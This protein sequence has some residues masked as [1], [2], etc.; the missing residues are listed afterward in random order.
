MTKLGNTDELRKLAFQ[1]EG[2]GPLKNRETLNAAAATKP[3]KDKPFVSHARTHGQT[4]SDARTDERTEERV[5][6]L[7]N[8]GSF[9]SNWA[10]EL[11]KELQNVADI[12]F[13]PG[14]STRQNTR[15]KQRPD[16]ERHTQDENPTHT[17]ACWEEREQ[18]NC[19]WEQLE[20]AG[21][22]HHRKNTIKIRKPPIIKSWFGESSEEDS[23]SDLSDTWTEVDK[24]KRNQERRRRQKRMRKEKE[25]RL[26][27][28]AAGMAGVGPIR[29]DDVLELVAQ[30]LDFEKAKVTT[31][32][33]FLKDRLGYIDEELDT[34]SLV[35]TKFA[36]K[37]DNVLNIAM[38]NQEHI[39]ELHVRRAECQDDSITVRNFIPPNYYDR[40]MALNRI[41]AEKRA[42][43]PDLKTQLRFGKTDVE[44]FIK[45]RGEPMG[46]KVTKLED[47]TD[48]S[49]LPPFQS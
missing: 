46:Y 17:P 2:S 6:E 10:L 35:E 40:Y 19:S 33:N 41:C 49:Q 31:F 36:T 1:P 8:T 29:M 24:K 44:V 37:G 42:V 47:F 43:E 45:Y 30:G 25:A 39:R 48:T 34:L 13:Q 21:R 27:T 20:P 26:A 11:E 16:K 3:V 14:G 18:D 32:K 38:S 7:T 4:R 9:R 28:K 15:Q 23:E 5:N 22:Q 12:E